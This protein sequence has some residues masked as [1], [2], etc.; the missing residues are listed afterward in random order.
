MMLSA[1][2]RRL[3]AFHEAGHSLVGL[4]L[5]RPLD[6]VVVNETAL[7]TFW[8]ECS[9]TSDLEECLV[10]IA[11]RCGEG[12]GTQ[13][14]APPPAVFLEEDSAGSDNDYVTSYFTEYRK[15]ADL[16]RSPEQCLI[17]MIASVYSMIEDN[18]SSLEAVTDEL[19]RQG[20]L[21]GDRVVEI[22][23]EN[24][25][26]LSDEMRTYYWE[27]PNRSGAKYQGA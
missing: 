21:T 17:D 5:G 3:V 6:S 7:A 18:A 4:L 25:A 10:A 22:L 1:G 2:Q 23:T 20:S 16:T 19:W 13:R 27:R 15:M 26:R 14:G 9:D 11:G 8:T 24:V 12:F